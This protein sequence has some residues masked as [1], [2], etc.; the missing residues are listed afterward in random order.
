MSDINKE[1]WTFGSYPT[2]P[3]LVIPGETIITSLQANTSDEKIG[4][5]NFSA[6][7]SLRT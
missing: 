6:P 7:L 3:R 2:V 5:P 4:F 1:E